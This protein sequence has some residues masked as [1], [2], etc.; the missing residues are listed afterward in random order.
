MPRPRRRLLIALA[1]LGLCGAGCDEPAP[2]APAPA[3]AP[4]VAPEPPAPAPASDEPV[5]VAP[6]PAA[7]AIDLLHAVATTVRASSAFRGDP[8]QVER[9]ADGD[10]ETAWNSERGEHVGAWIE[11][12]LPDDATV[13][14]IEMTVGFT[15]R[16][17]T[18][19]LFTSNHRVERVRVTRAGATLVEHALDPSSRE[20]QRVPVAGPGGRYRIELV[21]LRAGDRADWREAVVSELRVLG[22]APG[23][24]PGDARPAFEVALPSAAVARRQMLG[25]RE[26]WR[27]T[28]DLG[29]DMLPESTS[30]EEGLFGVALAQDEESRS[31]AILVTRLCDRDRLPEPVLR[32]QAD[33]RAARAA[34]DRAMRRYLDRFRRAEDEPPWERAMQRS[35]R[36]RE[37]VDAALRA[38]WTDACAR[39]RA[40]ADLQR[41]PWERDAGE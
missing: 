17:D 39:S 19:D 26:E 37:R 8:G 34:E 11:V 27:S 38:M 13:E 12:D 6:R 2:E 30:W 4:A 40:D 20:L 10:L 24:R 41:V 14:G 33:L 1:A 5:E 18:R 15:K 25:A 32:A 31:W 23:V 28:V 7:R 22:T 9:I 35:G 29:L 21:E 36:A 16:T 3:P